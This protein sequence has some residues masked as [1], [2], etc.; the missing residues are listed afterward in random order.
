LATRYTSDIVVPRNDGDVSH[1]NPSERLV[2]SSNGEE[3]KVDKDRGHISRCHKS[4]Y[5]WVEKEK[6]NA[7]PQDMEALAS[8]KTKAHG[9]VSNA[10]L[11]NT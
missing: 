4:K 9:H 11:K 2:V 1:E 7:N 5:S 8:R 6:E 3:V 10:A